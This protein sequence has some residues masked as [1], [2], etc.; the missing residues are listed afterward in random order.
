MCCAGYGDTVTQRGAHH[1]SGT[2]PQGTQR[3]GTQAVPTLFGSHLSTV[4]CGSPATTS[5]P[6]ADTTSVRPAAVAGACQRNTRRA[7]VADSCPAPIGQ[8]IAG[9]APVAV[10]CRRCGCK[11][12]WCW[13]RVEGG[14]DPRACQAW[15]VLALRSRP[16]P[17]TACPKHSCS[18]R[19]LRNQARH[20]RQDNR[21]GK[22]AR[23]SCRGGRAAWRGSRSGGNRRRPPGGWGRATRLQ[24]R[25]EEAG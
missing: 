22:C 21:A 14:Q 3:S 15:H 4:S 9:T 20:G 17:T 6:Q 24:D 25:Q 23:A 5:A 19:K 12:L 10:T 16:P 8:T 18:H 13:G 7:P 1:S 2:S 11:A